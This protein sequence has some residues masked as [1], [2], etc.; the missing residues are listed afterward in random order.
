MK[1]NVKTSQ[2]LDIVNITRDVENAIKVKDGAV[3]VYTPHTT[4]A[5][6]LN[7]DESNLRND[8]KMFYSELAKG[9]WGHNTIDNNAEAHLASST[10]NPS[11]VLPVENSRLVLGTWQS[12]LF[13]ELDGPRERSVYIK[14]LK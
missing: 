8:M 12:I 1:I 9:S 6:V 13:V 4:G 7:E 3:L 11:L 2:K 5:L 10:L 14:E